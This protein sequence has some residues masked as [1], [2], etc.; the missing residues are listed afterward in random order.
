MIVILDGKERSRG[1]LRSTVVF[2][3]LAAPW[4]VLAV[5]CVAAGG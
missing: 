5:V 4:S 1:R 2:L 3:R